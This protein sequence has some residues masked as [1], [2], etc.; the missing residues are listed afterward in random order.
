MCLQH[1]GRGWLR[2]SVLGSLG[3][4]WHLR[5]VAVHFG[6]IPPSAEA[7]FAWLLNG[8][9]ETQQETCLAQGLAEFS[10]AAH[11]NPGT[12][13]KK[14]RPEPSKDIPC[15][16]SEVCTRLCGVRGPLLPGHS[17]STLAPILVAPGCLHA[18]NVPCVSAPLAS[19]APFPCLGCPARLGG[20]QHP[21]SPMLMSP[22][23][24]VSACPG[25]QGPWLTCRTCRRGPGGLGPLGVCARWTVGTLPGQGAVTNV[26]RAL[27]VNGGAGCK[28]MS[29]CLPVEYLDTPVMG[30]S[31]HR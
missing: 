18:P 28:L 2:A 16:Q 14:P 25:G 15:A 4:P 8:D 1:P 20:L 7:R 21:A 27:L 9:K 24:R 5:F 13:A 11:C 19:Y 12:T 3:L 26:L 23:P 22:R 31:L 6:H 29:S 10:V 30:N 17:N